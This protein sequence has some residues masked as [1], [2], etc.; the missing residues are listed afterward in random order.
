MYITLPNRY[1]R[2]YIIFL[3]LHLSSNLINSFS[4]GRSIFHVHEDAFLV[5]AL[6]L[7]NFSHLLNTDSALLCYENVINAPFL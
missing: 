4:M 5:K 2:I 6:H 7:L 3:V 1:E